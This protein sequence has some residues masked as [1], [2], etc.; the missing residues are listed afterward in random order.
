MTQYQVMSDG[1]GREA[2]LGAPGSRVHA[3]TCGV[4]GGVRYV[5]RC[6]MRQVPLL[7]GS[8]HFL[9]LVCPVAS[10]IS[11]TGYLLVRLCGN[12]CR[13]SFSPPT[14]RATESRCV[15][16][17]ERERERRG[18]ERGQERGRLRR[19][20]GKMGQRVR[21]RERGGGGGGSK[22]ETGWGHREW[23]SIR[24]ETPIDS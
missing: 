18:E 24:C 23:D 15:C 7:V 9:R 19:C 4:H 3:F 11:L 8:T 1:V 17:R 22:G 2:G 5:P 12:L 13:A 21:V 20:R 14:P 16:V 6:A 10:N